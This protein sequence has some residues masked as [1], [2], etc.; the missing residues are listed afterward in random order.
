VYQTLPNQT[1]PNQTLPNQT[2]PNQTLPNQTLPNQTLPNQTLPDQT[3]PDQ[4]LTDDAMAEA[5]KDP[6]PSALQSQASFKP[7][8]V[9]I[10]GVWSTL[11]KSRRWSKQGKD[12]AKEILTGLLALPDSEFDALGEDQRAS[13][14]QQ[15]ELGCQTKVPQEIRDLAEQVLKRL[16]PA[17][18]SVS[19]Q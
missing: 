7:L 4:T 11:C 18:D 10:L 3:L 5:F 19:Q 9:Q 6:H 14:R 2:L 1:L 17:A 15:I 16:Q 12:V 13:I 8:D